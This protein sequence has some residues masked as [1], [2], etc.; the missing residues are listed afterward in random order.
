MS[1]TRLHCPPAPAIDPADSALVMGWYGS[2]NKAD[3][4]RMDRY[5]EQLLETFGFFEGISIPLALDLDTNRRLPILHSRNIVALPVFMCDGM[6][7]KQHFP[8]MLRQLAAEQVANSEIRVASI[9]GHHESL[10][11]LVVERATRCLDHSERKGNLLLVAHGSERFQGSMK[12]TRAVRDRI[13][14]MGRFYDVED[15][16]LEASPEVCN[17]IS[18]IHGDCVVE[19]LFL[20]EGQHSTHDLEAS[21]RSV[22]VDF[23]IHC[24]GAVGTDPQFIDVLSSIVR[25]A[26]SH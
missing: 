21:L 11:R 20:T 26:L 24:L 10:A 4:M 18:G 7:M 16:Y 25:D 6:A 8:A 15:A 22:E 5:L 17:V 14:A 2:R 3:H 13:R 12:A 1:G 19:G 23:S 9:V